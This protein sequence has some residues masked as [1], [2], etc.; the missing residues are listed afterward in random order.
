MAERKN[1]RGQRRRTN[2]ADAR[3][4]SSGPHAQTKD[5]SG[6]SKCGELDF[7]RRTQFENNSRTSALSQ[8]YSKRTGQIDDCLRWPRQFLRSATSDKRQRSTFRLPAVNERTQRATQSVGVRAASDFFV[9]RAVVD[10]R[11]R[12]W[13]AVHSS[14]LQLR[15]SSKSQKAPRRCGAYVSSAPSTAMLSAEHLGRVGK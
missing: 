8:G 7:H 15:Q 1:W 11:Q 3:A 4:I 10:G 9:G 13:A 2:W 12:K 5:S 6:K 14:S